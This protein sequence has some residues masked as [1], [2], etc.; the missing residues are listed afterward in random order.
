MSLKTVFECVLQVITYMVSDNMNVSCQI[1]V[2][3]YEHDKMVQVYSSQQTMERALLSISE[4]GRSS[5]RL[6]VTKI[7]QCVAKQEAIGHIAH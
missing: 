4:I 3:D 7:A 5:K 2:A 1:M 6:K